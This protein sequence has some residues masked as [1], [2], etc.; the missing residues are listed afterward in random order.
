[1]TARATGGG[2][3]Q[4]AMAERCEEQGHQWETVGTGG[5]RVEMRCKWCGA[6]KRQ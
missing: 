4:A 2:T 3:L 5:L 6:R 1:M